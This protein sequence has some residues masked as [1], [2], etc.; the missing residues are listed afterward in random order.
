LS[1][2]F[3]QA[4][5]EGFHKEYR[6]L[7]LPMRFSFAFTLLASLFLFA[8]GKKKPLPEEVNFAEHIAPIVYEN[9]TPCHRSGEAGPFPLMTFEDVS[10]RAKLIRQVTTTRFMPPWPAD[11]EYVHFVGEKVLSNEEIELLA[12]WAENGAKPGD[13]PKVPPPPVY[14]SGSSFGKPDMVIKMPKTFQIEGNN[15]DHFRVMKLPFELPF[16]TFVRMFE[17]VPGNKRLLH[18]MNGHLITYT[19]NG[20]QNIHAGEMAVNTEAYDSRVIHRMLDLLNDDGTYPLMSPSVSNYLPGVEPAQYPDGIGGWR[21]SKKGALYL[22][23]VHYGPSAIHDS[24]QSYFNVFFAPGPPQRPLQEFQMGTLGVSPIEPPLVIPPDVIKTYVTR[25]T[26]PQDISV[27]TVNPHMHLLGKSFLAY[28]LTPQGDTIRLVR[29][30]KWDFRWQ[31][32]YTFPKMLKIPAG[33]TL[34]AEGVFDNT[35]DNPNNPFS[36]PRIVRDREGS[37]RT[38]DEMFQLIVTYLPY[39]PGDENIKLSK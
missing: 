37:M 39:Q 9:C 4:V 24:D 35:K 21:I 12:Q 26:V 18:H 38:T 1:S 36:P 10:K 6:T 29:L 33:S 25:Y 31:Y 23:D 16:D 27:L 2:V 5:V 20:K 32:F 14:P 28:A 7:Y 17:F 13:L 15:T 30:K 34:V 3:T 8:C 11:P 22:N 19:D